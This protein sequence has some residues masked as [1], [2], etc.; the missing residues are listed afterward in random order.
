[1]A[2]I[3]DHYYLQRNAD[4]AWQ[5]VEQSPSVAVLTD[6]LPDQLTAPG[7]A[8]IRI[9]GAVFD[10]QS[11]RWSYEQLFYI[12]QS[13]IDLGIA[14]QEAGME[15]LEAETPD[16]TIPNLDP[17]PAITALREESQPLEDRVSD[18][19]PRAEAD[20]L[21]WSGNLSSDEEVIKDDE[22][23]PDPDDVA[24]WRARDHDLDEFADDAPAPW[25][26]TDD[27]N[28]PEDI[29]PEPFPFDPSK[30]RGSSVG[31]IVLTLLIAVVLLAV[32][33]LGSMIYFQH[34]ILLKHADELGIGDYI[35]FGDQESGMMRST[36]MPPA[37][38]S[39][40]AVEQVEPL[41]T[42]QVVRYTGVPPSL[43]GRWSP[44]KCDTTFIEFTE[45]GYHRTV[46]GQSSAK[47]ARVLETLED[48]FQFYLRRS[49]TV[50]EH[51]RRVTP[52]DIQLA[53]ATTES[54]FLE[55]STKA[56]I[57]SRCR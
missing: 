57:Y 21:P 45:D 13:S 8:E 25:L 40:P 30:R 35:R 36:T 7:A 16:S 55:S 27:T 49:P 53:G 44:R 12:D 50:V 26:I 5:T 29:A 6:S 18:P 15:P 41:T 32:A 23:P 51:Y 33:G 2:K 20:P 24:P 48:E 34:P 39:G 28:D 54:G 52:N 31:K 38:P 37:M 42:G 56:E 47:I 14:D 17:G 43:H 10:E 46:N 1:M 22:T 19:I 9:V 3:F 11:E 4:R